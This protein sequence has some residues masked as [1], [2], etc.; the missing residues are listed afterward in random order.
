MVKLF[1]YA[2]MSLPGLP[3]HHYG[4]HAHRHP[5]HERVS[6]HALLGFFSHRVLLGGP[7]LLF[8]L[9]LFLLGLTL[10][11][12]LLPESMSDAALGFT[13]GNIWRLSS[14]LRGS[15]P[16]GAG[17]GGRFRIVVFGEMDVASPSS[18]DDAGVTE[19]S[20]W[21]EVLCS[22]VCSPG[23]STVFPPTRR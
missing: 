23:V 15:G 2:D 8:H 5:R 18:M 19:Q 20:S 11:T 21:T 14:A 17:A 12:R 6:W 3:Y 7:R 13:Y 9:A 16:Y 22:Q 10:L 1:A 4:L